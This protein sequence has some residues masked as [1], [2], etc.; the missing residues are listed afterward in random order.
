[1]PEKHFASLTE[2]LLR[3]GV[4]PTHV[5]RLVTELESHYESLL[6][7]ERARGQPREVAQELARRK[8]GAD[9]EI[10]KRVLEQP[11]LKSWGARW[12]FSFC[13]VGPTLALAV[14]SVAAI[15]AL[16]LALQVGG[17]MD[18]A[19]SMS[20]A[21]V[22]SWLRHGTERAGL[23][24][25]YG[26]PVLWACL[27]A[28]Y[29]ATRRLRVLWPLTGILLIAVLGATTNFSIDWP[30]AGIAGRVSAGVGFSTQVA[31]LVSLGLRS[32]VAV[33][34]AVAAYYLTSRRT[35]GR[36]SA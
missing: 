2:Q 11:A 19:A 35:I 21:G 10:V 9:E 6:E 31:S 26:L 36:H 14:S 34:F 8:L 13:G 20:S 22:P 32:L 15:A 3:A 18:P 25:I 27:L 28:R 17:Y 16:V 33:V 24:V 5:R 12:P 4:A 29:A 7:D 23:L 1:M 30:H